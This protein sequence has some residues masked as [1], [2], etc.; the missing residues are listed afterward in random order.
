MES[1]PS[2]RNRRKRPQKKRALKHRKTSS[3]ALDMNFGCNNGE[4]HDLHITDEAAQAELNGIDEMGTSDPNK[5]I[6]SEE[7]ARFQN[8]WM[9]HGEMLVWRRWVQKYPDHI[10]YD[11]VASVPP[12]EEVEVVEEVGVVNDVQGVVEQCE[13]TKSCSQDDAEQMAKITSRTKGREVEVTQDVEAVQRGQNNNAKEISETSIT[14]EEL[15]LNQGI[16]DVHSVDTSGDAHYKTFTKRDPGDSAAASESLEVTRTN[17]NTS[18]LTSTD[19][20]TPLLIQE[21]DARVQENVDTK[22]EN[23]IPLWSENSIQAAVEN[24]DN[25]VNPEK[26]VNC[27]VHAMDHFQERS[28]LIQ[29]GEE[30]G[31]YVD[32]KSAAESVSLPS[33]TPLHL[34]GLNQAIHAIMNRVSEPDIYKS[35]KESM[36]AEGNQDV[37]EPVHSLAEKPFDPSSS[38]SQS[39]EAI[40][41]MHSYAGPSEHQEN[42]LC[43]GSECEK[44][45]ESDEVGIVT[46]YVRALFCLKMMEE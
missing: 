4:S 31:D 28:E 41:M 26:D 5:P 40:F 23:K 7:E 35:E 19:E 16:I 22:E 38:T 24:S 32:R 14:E 43:N 8:F 11:M 46:A 10:N 42:R 18:L 17:Q 34:V 33:F 3:S 9:Q 21:S 6:M 44:S 20:N 27:I 1:S 39:A 37:T 12:I 45:A 15:I 30:N 29:S 13:K 36:P 2:K 25:Q